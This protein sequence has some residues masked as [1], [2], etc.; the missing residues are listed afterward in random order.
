M[1]QQRSPL[2]PKKHHKRS[3][4]TGSSI[5]ETPEVID[6]VPREEGQ[7]H[8]TFKEP[9]EDDVAQA[10][11]GGEHAKSPPKKTKKKRELSISPDDA[12]D[13]PPKKTKRSSADDEPSSQPVY[14]TSA[15]EDRLSPTSQSQPLETA[16]DEIIATD[17][18]F[19]QLV[20]E[21]WKILKFRCL[22][23]ANDIRF[24]RKEFHPIFRFSQLTIDNYQTTW[25][26]AWKLLH[27]PLLVSNVELSYLL[28]L[29]RCTEI[30]F[31]NLRLP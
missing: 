23:A 15:P 24:C 6:D 25:D 20:S 28:E 21:I 4:T 29:R 12:K 14:A 8:V 10:L 27:T 11:I 16:D 17:K 1:S 2:K 26:I 22:E 18:S 30:P 9:S 13:G 19:G 7:R 5:N 31:R 3:P